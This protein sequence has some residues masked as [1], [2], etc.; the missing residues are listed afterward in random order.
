[1][2]GLFK[3]II[4]IM[5]IVGIINPRIAWQ[6][7]EGWKFKDAEPSVIYLGMTR[8]MSVVMLIVLWF[9]IRI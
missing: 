8:V 4:S 9:V 7:S 6:M 1:V 2:F 3:V 5:L